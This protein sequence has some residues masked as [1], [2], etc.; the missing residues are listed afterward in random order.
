MPTMKELEER[1]KKLEEKVLMQDEIIKK[2]LDF[3]QH[4]VDDQFEKRRAYYKQKKKEVDR[5]LKESEERKKSIKD[6][7]IKLGWKFDKD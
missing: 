1:I 4:A 3:V 7:M 2:T 6:K 5:V